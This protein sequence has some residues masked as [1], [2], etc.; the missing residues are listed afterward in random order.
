MSMTCTG[1]PKS[2]RENHLVLKES[3]KAQRKQNRERKAL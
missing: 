1:H 3:F 2:T